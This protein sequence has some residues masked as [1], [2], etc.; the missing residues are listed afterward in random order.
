MIA[1]AFLLSQVLVR[2]IVA[3][4]SDI[5]RIFGG[6]VEEL[7]IEF[8]DTYIGRFLLDSLRVYSIF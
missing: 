4:F 8:E 2:G 1:L 7:R 6:F 3:V 5:R